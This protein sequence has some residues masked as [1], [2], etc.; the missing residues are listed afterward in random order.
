M[1]Q[2]IWV[3][4]TE[5][6][7]SARAL[8]AL[9]HQALSPAHQIVLRF[10]YLYFIC[11]TVLAYLYVYTECMQWLKKPE[12]CIGCLWVFFI[13]DRHRTVHI[14]GYSVFFQCV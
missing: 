2:L 7:S 4:G 11:M 9:N 10:T 14:W 6:E 5:V 13:V 1:S 12:V 3:L 8:S